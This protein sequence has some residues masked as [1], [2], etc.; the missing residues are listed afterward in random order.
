MAFIKNYRTQSHYGE[1]RAQIT[2]ILYKDP[3]VFNY[4]A[5]TDDIIET[6]CVSGETRSKVNEILTF[7][8]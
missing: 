4:L 8:S 3:Y 5:I 6:G 2:D 7:E 1:N